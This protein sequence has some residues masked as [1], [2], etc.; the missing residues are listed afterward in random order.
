[1]MYSLQHNV[2][3][4]CN[5][6]H[7]PKALQHR[8]DVLLDKV[9]SYDCMQNPGTESE[10]FQKLYDCID[11]F[12]KKNSLSFFTIRLKDELY[13][14]INPQTTKALPLPLRYFWETVQYYTSNRALNILKGDPLQSNL[15]IPST[16]TENPNSM[17][18]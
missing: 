13:R 2:T 18:W 4:N 15:Y 10:L 17:F 5:H 14:K 8:L 1:M 12:Q 11:M 7:H 3:S 16:T 6:L 9:K